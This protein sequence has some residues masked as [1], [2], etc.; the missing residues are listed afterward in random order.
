MN[1]KIAVIGGGQMGSQIA[2]LAAMAGYETSL[3]DENEE[4]LEYR[5]KFVEENIKNLIDK[6]IY[7][8]DKLD[9]YK[10]NLELKFTLEE[11]IHEKSFVIEAVVERFDVKLEIFK[12]ISSL[13]NDEVVMAT[14]SSF[15]Q[16]SELSKHCNHPE[17]FINMHFFYPPIRMDLVEISYPENVSKVILERTKTVSKNMGR[18]VV[19]L[20][21]ETPGFIVNRMLAALVDEAYELYDEGIAD[22]EDIDIA[23][24]KGL[25]HPLGPFELSDYSGLD[26]HY[27]AKLKKFKESGSSEDKPKK[28]LEEKVLNG[29]LGV[30]TGK[31]FYEY[32]KD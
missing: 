19:V 28:F 32:K 7:S 11:V 21:K 27:Y 8:E 2:A 26:I 22:F 12:K 18:S 4:N 3:Y 25:N 13:M 1:E 10:K 5:Y 20:K 31:G 14:N 24:K 17:R 9:A 29:D 6:K 15:I 16:A 30:K 23:I